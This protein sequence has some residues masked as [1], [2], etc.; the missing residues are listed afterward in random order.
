MTLKLTGRV[1]EM[2]RDERVSPGEL[3]HLIEDLRR[4]RQRMAEELDHRNR[5][6]DQREE[7][8]AKKDAVP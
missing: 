8:V 4:L 7:V 2:D 6:P 5:V 3:Q 1:S